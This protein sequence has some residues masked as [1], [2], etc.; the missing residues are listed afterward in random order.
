MKTPNF[1]LLLLIAM[2]IVSC[3]NSDSPTTEN[4]FSKLIIGKWTRETS[5]ICNYREFKSD[6]TVVYT[7]DNCTTPIIDNLTYKIE[8]NTLKLFN[9]VHGTT[10]TNL[11][12]IISIT[13]SEMKVSFSGGSALPTEYRTFYKIK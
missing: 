11:E 10:A 8:G 4:P 3:T 9:N 6:G 12:T 7:Q 13:E 1:I 2:L 5:P